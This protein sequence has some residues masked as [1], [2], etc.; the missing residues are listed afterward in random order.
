[1]DTMRRTPR[2]LRDVAMLLAALIIVACVAPAASARRTTFV[3]ISGG[4]FVGI[5]G[6]TL[7]L[8]GADRSGTEYSCA[9]PVGGGGFGYGV[10]QGPADDRSIRAM[11]TWDINV[12]ALPLNEACWLGGYGGLSPDFTGRAYRDA[13]TQYVQRLHHFGIY[14]VLRLSGAA[15]GDRA[16][17]SDTTSSNEVP[18]ADADHSLGFWSS[19]ASTFK[20]DKMVLFHTFD[21]PHD[22]N[23]AC[24]LHGCIAND[25]PDGKARF[26][27]YQTVGNQAIVKSIR[28]A[29]AQQP[30]IVSG[31]EFAG[32]LSGWQQNMP[33]DPRHQLAADVSS[34]DYADYVL[35]HRNALRAFARRHPVIVGGFGDTSCTSTYSA[36]V[37]SFMDSIGQSYIAWTWDTVQDYGGCANALLDDAG[38]LVSGQPAGYY[39]A[40]PSG[41]GQGI[42]AHYRAINPRRHDAG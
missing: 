3:H 7:R 28:S 9:G 34:F 32:D 40:K 14:V 12:V 30:I 27:S 26:G 6:K 10:F 38:P 42:R 8:I 39:S 4:R 18:M 29:G 21:E 25:A 33:L 11:V 31:P 24:L 22:I 20:S 37:M 5:H 35:A 23:W 36:K 41:F 15:P 1:M 13:I 2:S 19:V 16:F 17:G